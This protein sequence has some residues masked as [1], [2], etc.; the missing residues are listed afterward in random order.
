MKFK[1]NAIYIEVLMIQETV[2]FAVM[3][4]LIYKDIIALGAEIV[5]K[6]VFTTL[7]LMVLAPVPFVIFIH[8]LFYDTVYYDEKGIKIMTRKKTAE[9]AWDDIQR[10]ERIIGGRSGTLGWTLVA[11]TGEKY[12]VFPFSARFIEFVK[13]NSPYLEIRMMP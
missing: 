1:R 9:Y 2:I 5:W 13:K 10:I 8:G 6:D 11:L 3:L 4:F 7:G 12:N